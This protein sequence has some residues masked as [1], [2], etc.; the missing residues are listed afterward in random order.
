MLDAA[1]PVRSLGSPSTRRTTVA[2]RFI[3]RGVIST[4]L[5]TVHRLPRFVLCGESFAND[6]DEPIDLAHLIP[7]G[8]KV[9]IGLRLEFFQPL[10]QLCRRRRLSCSRFHTVI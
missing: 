9:A 5:A 3:A 7:Q 2:V 1:P 6:G 10:R 4:P 8:A